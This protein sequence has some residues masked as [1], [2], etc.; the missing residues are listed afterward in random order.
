[1]EEEIQRIRLDGTTN[2]LRIMVIEPRFPEDEPAILA[3]VLRKRTLSRFQRLLDQ[4]I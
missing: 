2:N 1:M 3:I 4:Y